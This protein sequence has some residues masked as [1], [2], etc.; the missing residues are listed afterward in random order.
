MPEVMA[1][2]RSPLDYEVSRSL[3]GWTL[4]EVGSELSL[5]ITAEQAWV[6]VTAMEV[7]EAGEKAAARE[8]GVL[9]H[10]LMKGGCSA[11]QVEGKSVAE[12][13]AMLRAQFG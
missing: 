4:C 5:V 12:L 13:K 1:A 9:R 7:A 8:A 3:L 6:I 11:E 2:M 10:R